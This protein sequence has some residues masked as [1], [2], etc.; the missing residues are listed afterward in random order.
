MRVVV[1]T[2]VPIVANGI[3]THV[4]VACQIRCIETLQGIVQSDSDDVAFLDTKGLLL[5]EYRRYLNFQGHP[6][7]GDTFFKYLHDHMYGDAKVKL[8]EIT[9][10]DDESRGFE[11]LPVN[12]L[13]RA[14]RKI[15]AI[16]VVANASVVNA[17]DSDWIEQVALLTQLDV[18][19]QQL[20]PEHAGET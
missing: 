12:N 13:D 5:A 2:N 16:A 17:T 14:D 15:L 10:S 6:G 20:C 18:H 3:G 1:D 4:S 8:V 7:V 11:E 9:P 19:V